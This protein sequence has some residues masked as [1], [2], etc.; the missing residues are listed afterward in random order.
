M[1]YFSH[2]SQP[3]FPKSLRGYIRAESAN[4]TIRLRGNNLEIKSELSTQADGNL[5]IEAAA[6]DSK[7]EPILKL[8]AYTGKL[9]Q[10]NGW[11]Y[12]VVIDLK[13]A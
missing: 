12:P 3:V 8:T 4:G 11:P 7:E 1:R 5:E 10:L 6:A 9:M 2:K 13:G